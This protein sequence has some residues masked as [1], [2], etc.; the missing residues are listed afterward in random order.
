MSRIIFRTMSVQ[1]NLRQ[2]LKSVHS[3]L[4]VLIEAAGLD[5]VDFEVRHAVKQE[6]TEDVPEVHYQVLGKDKRGS[7]MFALSVKGPE[8]KSREFN[9]AACSTHIYAEGLRSPEGTDV[10]AHAWMVTLTELSPA[11]VKVK[12][13][14]RYIFDVVDTHMSVSYY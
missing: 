9:E 1:D 13:N 6:H 5:V 4:S 10:L 8:S 12:D 14:E 7:I 2:A 3:G 11:K